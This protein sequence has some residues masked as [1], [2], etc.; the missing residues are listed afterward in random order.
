MS[1]PSGVGC[2]RNRVWACFGQG[3]SD[4]DGH[5]SASRV[6]ALRFSSLGLAKKEIGAIELAAHTT[7]RIAVLVWEVLEAQTQ[8]ADCVLCAWSAGGSLAIALWPLNSA[9]TADVCSRIARV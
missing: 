4:Q 2:K 8:R 9:V 7:V 6:R 1:G 5:L 3:R